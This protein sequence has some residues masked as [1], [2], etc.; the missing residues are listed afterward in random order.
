MLAAAPPA[1]GGDGYHMIVVDAFTQELYI[2]FHLG[3][4]EFFEL[5][6]SRLAPGGILAMNVYAYRPDSPNMVAL[7]NTLATVFGSAVRVRQFWEGNFALYARN[8][9]GPP[10]VTR[11]APLRIRQRFGGRDDLAE[12]SDLM[13]LAERVPGK[14]VVIRPDPTLRVLT[15]DDAPIEAMMD[16][17][18]DRK[19]ERIRGE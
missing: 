16:E 1:S 14:S 11:L 8:A 15:D 9:E 5:C 10:D 17:M 2:P 6:R 4:R 3:T 7:Q 12:W 18:I 13:A 19:E